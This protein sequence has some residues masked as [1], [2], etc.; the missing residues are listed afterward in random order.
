MYVSKISPALAQIS[1]SKASWLASINDNHNIFW[2]QGMGLPSLA[3]RYLTM[4]QLLAPLA[5]Q[6]TSVKK[7][8]LCAL[9]ALCPA[10][11][12]QPGPSSEIP[13]SIVSQKPTK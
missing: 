8:V 12:A 9:F 2:A 6:L 4:W 1:G 13:F 10:S 3:C 7:N 11:K 5:T